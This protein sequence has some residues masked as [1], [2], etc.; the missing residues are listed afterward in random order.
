MSPALYE[1]TG[2]VL[3]ELAR[4]KGVINPTNGYFHSY[5]TNSWSANEGLSQVS[6]ILYL[7][8]T[9]LGYPSK[10]CIYFGHHDPSSGKTLGHFQVLICRNI[11]HNGLCINR[12]HRQDKF[13][14]L[15]NTNML[16]GMTD[17]GVHAI[18]LQGALKQPK[19]NN[20]FQERKTT[21]S[22]PTPV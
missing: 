1:Q 2:V 5:Y 19:L 10:L 7:V 12:S 15:S 14:V 20:C 21:T 8:N 16:D 11:N 22:K 13:S 9:N 4:G 18:L 3:H 6:F 17:K